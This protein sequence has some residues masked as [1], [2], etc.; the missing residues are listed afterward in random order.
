ME[1]KNNISQDDKV[2]AI[3][4]Q[5]GFLNTT[6]E[7]VNQLVEFENAAKQIATK[8]EQFI[9]NHG[10][11]YCGAGEVLST[12]TPSELL[13][14][15]TENLAI[16][17]TNG[18]SFNLE[19]TTIVYGDD[20]KISNYLPAVD[21]HLDC[22]TNGYVIKTYDDK[23]GKY[24][25]WEAS[26]DFNFDNIGSKAQGY[27]NLS[28]AITGYGET[29]KEALDDLDKSYLDILNKFLKLNKFQY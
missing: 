11:Y 1:N 26:I 14:I 9:L 10:S 17:G 4:Q 20:Y 5:D 2:N 23:K 12:S 25:S 18:Y 16:T 19:P 7:S 27:G 29:C 15:H 8:N 6:T 24:N 13:S 28:I 3:I 22:T 21:K